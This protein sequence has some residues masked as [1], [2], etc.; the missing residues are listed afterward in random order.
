MFI[1]L[2][3]FNVIIKEKYGEQPILHSEACI[4][5]FLYKR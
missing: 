1:K 2:L 3:K 5:C 4:T